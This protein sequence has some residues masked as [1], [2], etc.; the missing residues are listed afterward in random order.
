VAEWLA[1]ALG[2]AFDSEYCETQFFVN[3][4][5]GGV[6]TYEASLSPIQEWESGG[7]SWFVSVRQYQTE[8]P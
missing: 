3:I 4:H 7:P 2:R 6:Q 8:K 5:D 1:G